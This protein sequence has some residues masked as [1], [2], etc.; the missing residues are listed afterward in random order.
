MLKELW[1]L[2]S[3]VVFIAVIIFAIIGITATYNE[4]LEKKKKKEEERKRK[5]MNWTFE[6]KKKEETLANRND[7]NEQTT[8]F[9]MDRYSIT[10]FYGCS[11]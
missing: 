2:V 7:N 11:I 6:T 9:H 10:H 3:T 8:Y 5:E 1:E 4:W